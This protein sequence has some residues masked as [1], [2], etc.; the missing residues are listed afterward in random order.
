MIGG[1]GVQELL[2]V[3]VIALVLFGGKKLPE[4]G[5]NLGKALRS[6]RQAEEE[7]RREL[8]E[9]V[10][11][12]STEDKKTEQTAAGEQEETDERESNKAGKEGEDA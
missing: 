5:Q 6:F 8:E 2:I 4:V 11:E 1:L 12:Q 10:K 7:T 9:A 3:F